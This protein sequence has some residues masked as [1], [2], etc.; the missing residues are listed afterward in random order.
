MNDDG[1]FVGPDGT[2]HLYSEI[3]VRIREEHPE[4][5]DKHIGDQLDALGLRQAIQKG[6]TPHGLPFS[7]SEFDP[8]REPTAPAP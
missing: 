7:F 4:L 5:I 2:K 3:A 8:A 6:Y 1:Y